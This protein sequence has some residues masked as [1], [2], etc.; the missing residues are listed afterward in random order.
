MSPDDGSMPVSTALLERF[1]IAY[2]LVY[3]PPLTTFLHAAQQL[4]LQTIPGWEMFVQQAAEQVK[5]FT[6]SAPPSQ[7]LNAQ[8]VLGVRC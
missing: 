2:D 4:G 3:T 6:G 7:W 5:I 8:L 1:K